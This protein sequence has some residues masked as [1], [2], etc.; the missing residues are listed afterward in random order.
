[1][2][3]APSFHSIEIDKFDYVL[4]DFTIKHNMDLDYTDTKITTKTETKTETKTNAITKTETKTDTKINTNDNRQMKHD[5]YLLEKIRKRQDTSKVFSYVNRESYITCF[6][7]AL[8]NYK[9]KKHNIKTPI[10]SK[11]STADYLN[12]IIDVI[13]STHSWRQYIGLIDGR[14]L[15]NKFHQYMHMRLFESTYKI[16]LKKYFSYNKSSKLKNTSIDSTFA[17][18]KGLKEKGYSKFHDRKNGMKLSGLADGNGVLFSLSIYKGNTSDNITVQSSFS[19]AL[20]KPDTYKSRNNNR[21]RHNLSGDS[22]YDS[23]ENIKYLKKKGYN[24][25]IPIN[26]RNTKDPN[27]LKKIEEH[28]KKV[29]RSKAFKK[30][31]IIENQFSKL[32]AY[33]K[34]ASVYEKYAESYLSL[35]YI[36]SS[37]LTLNL[38]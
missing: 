33:P 27:K 23:A 12:G 36:A 28:N 30:R 34:L 3:V 25:L 26:P 17:R 2:K 18:S 32:K 19:K 35:A 1:M 15:N 13:Q 10:Y 29:H 4:N 9:K 7:K 31:Y 20:I 22:G 11:H 6:Q 8:D 37:C 16:I 21:H 24:V 38:I 14:V 5:S